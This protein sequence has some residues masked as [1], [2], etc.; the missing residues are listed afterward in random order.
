MSIQPIG[1]KRSF[2]SQK[3]RSFVQAVQGNF[4]HLMGQL[5]GIARRLNQ[6]IDR[7]QDHEDA[8][9][10]T[11]SDVS[12]IEVDFDEHIEEHA[13]FNP[14]LQRIRNNVGSVPPLLGVDRSREPTGFLGPPGS[15]DLTT[16][17]PGVDVVVDVAGAPGASSTYARAGHGHRLSTS[18]AVPAAVVAAE[19]GI[20][21]GAVYVA[22]SRVLCRL[23]EELAGLLD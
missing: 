9:Q 12:S 17:G 23:R 8:I 21:P 16:A 20:C 6:V 13:E 7:V 18:P 2:R 10:G 5:R 3:G 14:E 1:P 22:K 4:D 11:V 15:L 19:L